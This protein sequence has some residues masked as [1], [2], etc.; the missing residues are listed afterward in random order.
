MKN[1]KNKQSILKVAALAVAFALIL[2]LVPAAQAA[3]SVRIS[4]YNFPVTLSVGKSYSIKGVI[5]SSAKITSVTV[6]VRTQPNG[7]TRKTGCTIRPNAKSYN[8]SRVAKNI[9]FSSLPRGTYWYKVI[10]STTTSKNKV[11]LLRRFTVK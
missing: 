4:G 1:N 3:S 10:V 6:E 8:L 2:Q 7:G 11:I 5:S 9:R